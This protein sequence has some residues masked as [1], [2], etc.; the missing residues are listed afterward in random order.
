[1][2]IGVNPCLRKSN[3]K[4]QSQFEPGLNGAKSLLKGSYG[5]ISADAEDENKAKQSQFQAPETRKSAR[6][7]EKPLET[8]IN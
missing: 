5:N 6:K 1:V 3:L 4:K 2:F 7:R 8:Q